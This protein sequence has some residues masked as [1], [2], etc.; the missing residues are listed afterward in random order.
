MRARIG[1]WAVSMLTCAACAACS[2]TQLPKDEAGLFESRPSTT[3]VE[4]AELEIAGS[5]E[6]RFVSCPPPGEL[7]QAWVPPLPAWSPPSDADAE[8]PAKPRAELDP[9]RAS[10]E[11]ETA[12]A[13]RLATQS[14]IQETYPDFRQ[15]HY[16]GLRV[17]PTQDGHVAIV[18]RVGADGKVAKVEEYGACNL[19][20]DVIECMRASAG[21]LRFDPPPSGAMTV[22]IP[23]YF[24][25]SDGY[26]QARPSMNDSYTASAYITIEQAR[27]QLHMCEQAARGSGKGIEAS[28]TLNLTLDARGRVTSMRVEPWSG[29]QDLLMCAAQTFQALQF[30]PPPAKRGA[31]LARVVFNPRAGS[32]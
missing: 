31:V 22:T 10:V 19:S 8:K 7:G 32:R 24:T 3:S 5:G 17:D 1:L 25:S 2:S 12:A 9:T 27:P 23:A 6:D 20:S 16:K 11:Q 28:A 14:A 15:C 29:N 18:A 26:R 21:R 4:V 30:E 13:S